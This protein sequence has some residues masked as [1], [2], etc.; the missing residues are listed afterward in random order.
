MMFSF[1]CALTAAAMLVGYNDVLSGSAVIILTEK[2]V[3]TGNQICTST[4]FGYTTFGHN[5][6]ILSCSPNVSLK[7]FSIRPMYICLCSRADEEH[8]LPCNVHLPTRE[9]GCKS[10]MNHKLM[11][12]LKQGLLCGDYAEL[13]LA[14]PPILLNTS[15][16]FLNSPKLSFIARKALQVTKAIRLFSHEDDYLTYFHWHVLLGRKTLT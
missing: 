4:Y 9:L 14:L 12:D 11:T 6:Q 7:R 16:S 13:G 3:L 15:A 5:Q 1:M 8:H 10:G 2:I